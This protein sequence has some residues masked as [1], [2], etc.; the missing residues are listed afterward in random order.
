MHKLVQLPN[1]LLTTAEQMVSPHA[2]RRNKP[3]H[4][5]WPGAGCW[6]TPASLLHH[7]LPQ[8]HCQW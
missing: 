1:P 5:H 6:Q 8:S 7:Q 4:L 3:P 2:M